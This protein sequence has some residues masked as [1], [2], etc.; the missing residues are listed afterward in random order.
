MSD[1][2]HDPHLQCD[3]GVVL[4]MPFLF[5]VLWTSSEGIALSACYKLTQNH[6]DDGNCLI[7][8][9]ALLFKDIHISE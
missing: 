3:L 5:C 1:R 2:R 6:T 8:V 7:L 9:M 4:V